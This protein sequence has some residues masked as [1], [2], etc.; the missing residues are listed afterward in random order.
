MDYYGGVRWVCD[1]APPRVTADRTALP[2]G[3]QRAALWARSWLPW[4]V[5]PGCSIIAIAQYTVRFDRQ[6]RALTRREGVD[7]TRF[8]W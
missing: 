5:S 8:S 1:G 6:G 4:Y 2:L 7:G 3:S